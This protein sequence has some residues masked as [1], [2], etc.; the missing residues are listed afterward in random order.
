M[1][2]LKQIRHF[3]V[4]LLTVAAACLFCGCALTSTSY[5]PQLVLEL[6]PKETNS[7]QFFTTCPTVP[8][9][10]LGVVTVNGNGYANSDD[11]IKAAKK[12]AA[13]LGGDFILTENAGVD[14]S[15]V[16]IPGSSSYNASASWGSSAGNYNATGYSTGPSIIAVNRPWACFS[17]WA[18]AP[19]QLGI[20]YEGMTISGF[21]LDSPAES[22]GLKTGDKMIGIDGY[23]VQDQKLVLHLMRVKPGVSV[24]VSIRRDTLF[25]KEKRFDYKVI[26]IPNA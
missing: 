2:R 6:S 24:T 22:S 23:D 10:K 18:Y 3:L 13:K 5:T 25:Q 15:T 17:V 8:S 21:A 12:K 20:K 1:I 9:L 14:K 19:S 7:V 26:T 11:L 4:P 16:Y